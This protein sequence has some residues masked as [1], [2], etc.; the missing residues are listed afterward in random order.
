MG[1]HLENV[2]CAINIGGILHRAGYTACQ[3]H[4]GLAVS[5]MAAS[6]ISSPKISLSPDGS[7]IHYQSRSLARTAA[8]MAEHSRAAIALGEAHQ[9][10]RI[11]FD[12]RDAI[13]RMPI[14]AQY[15]YA[16]HQAGQLGLTRNW[17]IAMLVAPGDRSYDFL[18][19]ALINAGY[20][21]QLFN[22][23]SQA[24]EWLKGAADSAALPVQL[25]Y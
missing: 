12:S 21:A 25:P 22:D 24:V 4:G 10:R 5:D 23:E 7:Y 1:E 9:V 11:M 18:E 6:P 19:T 8:D 17:R 20:L 14:S 15:E 2:V 3:E 13:F 16:Y